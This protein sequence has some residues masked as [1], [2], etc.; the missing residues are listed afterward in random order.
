MSEEGERRGE[1]LFPL[2]TRS[3]EPLS[4]SVVL[5][6]GLVFCQI[7][8]FQGSPKQDMHLGTDGRGAEY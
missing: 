1:L 7:W 6:S 5:G 4:W 8:Y 2:Q 3:I